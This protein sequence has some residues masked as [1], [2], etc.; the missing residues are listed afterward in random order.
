MEECIQLFNFLDTNNDNF[1]DLQE[2]FCG[3]NS[4]G[5][6]FDDDER[7]ALVN[8]FGEMEGNS[9]S[10]EGFV[11]FYKDCILSHQVS[12]DEAELLFNKY[13]LNKDRFLDFNDLRYMLIGQGDIISEDEVN[14]LLRDYDVNGDRKLNLDEFL[15]SLY[16]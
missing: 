15:Q 2:L 10:F 5:L 13:D 9:L 3:E 12:R 11:E 1:L 4:I 8:R 16:G 14:S 7:Q 6:N